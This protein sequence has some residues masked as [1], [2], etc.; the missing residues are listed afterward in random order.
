MIWVVCKPLSV[1]GSICITF[2][3]LISIYLFE[4]LRSRLWK[5]DAWQDHFPMQ[6]SL[7]LCNM[8]PNTLPPTPCTRFLWK[9]STQSKALI[10]IVD[11][12]YL[13]PQGIPVKR[14]ALPSTPTPQ[15]SLETSLL[16]PE[17]PFK[18]LKKKPSGKWFHC[19]EV[20]KPMKLTLKKDI[21]F[22]G[23]KIKDSFSGKKHFSSVS[24]SNSLVS[25][26][27]PGRAFLAAT[28]PFKGL[29]LPHLLLT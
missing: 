16:K 8:Y 3:Y 10:W 28:P 12:L 4:R 17:N 7:G 5:K 22:P 21:H 13:L 20:K 27:D 23:G 24:P 29:D 18:S 2:L 26:L 1:L 19:L 14:L 25:V 9:V 11:V 15:R 6:I